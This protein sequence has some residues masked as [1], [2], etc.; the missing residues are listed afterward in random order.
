LA[1][2]WRSTPLTS[3]RMRTGS[4]L[5]PSTGGNA[6]TT[7]LPTLTPRGAT[8]SAVSTRKGRG[9]YGYRLHMAVDTATDL[10]LAWRV[11]TARSHETNA[12]A[13]LLDRLHALGINP[14]TCATDMGCDNGLMHDACTDRGIVPLIPLRETPAVKRGQDK[15]P[16]CEHGEWRFAG[17][18]YSRKATRWRCPTS[19]CEPASKCVKADRLHPLIPHETLRWQRLYRGRGAVEREFGWLKNDWAMA[20]LRVR[21]IERVRLHVDL[22]VLAKLACR[23]AAGRGPPHSRRKQ[24]SKHGAT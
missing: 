20:P 3:L 11:E 12:V 7:S 2:T 15:P 23:L 19:E 16:R 14:E 22:T 17:A 1:K 6:P 9:F 13:P 10:P 8:V 18:D 5:P 24:P 21:R 4:A